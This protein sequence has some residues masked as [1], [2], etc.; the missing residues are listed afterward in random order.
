MPEN[1]VEIGTNYRWEQCYELESMHWAIVTDESRERRSVVSHL[2]VVNHEWADSLGTP[3]P[4]C[5]LPKRIIELLN[6]DA[7]ELAI[8][9]DAYDRSGLD[10]SPCGECGHPVVCIPDGLPICEPCGLKLEALQ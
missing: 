3:F 5:E 6:S 8:Y 9:K 1:T 4:E 10:I 2:L 7:N